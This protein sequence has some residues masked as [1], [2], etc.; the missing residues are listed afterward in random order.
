MADH[1]SGKSTLT[2]IATVNA[3]M[4]ESGEVD[5]LDD[6][7][8]ACSFFQRTRFKTFHGW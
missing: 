7:Q 8:L 4:D 2:P 6:I 1:V 3:E 5:L